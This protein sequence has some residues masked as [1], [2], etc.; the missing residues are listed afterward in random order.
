MYQIRAPARPVTQ[1]EFP[2]PVVNKGRRWNRD[3]LRSGTFYMGM[4]CSH[5]EE[6]VPQQ[7]V[8]VTRDACMT[9]ANIGRLSSHLNIRLTMKMRAISCRTFHFIRHDIE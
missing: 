9:A 6:E 8:G 4:Q 2:L 7:Q 3:V 1:K 5:P